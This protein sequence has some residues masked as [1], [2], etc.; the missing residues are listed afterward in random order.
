MAQ[1]LVVGN[2][3]GNGSNVNQLAL[4]LAPRAAVGSVYV[5][6]AVENL[7]NALPSIS[8]IDNV[9]NVYNLIQSGVVNF[10]VL[11]HGN[12]VFGEYVFV[13]DGAQLGTP[14]LKSNL[15]IVVNLGANVTAVNAIA[16]QISG[17]ANPSYDQAGVNSGNSSGA[18]AR[19]VPSQG[20][21]LGFVF[22]GIA[23]FI[24]ATVTSNPNAP[25]SNIV[26]VNGNPSQYDATS[27]FN[28]PTDVSASN[29]GNTGPFVLI[30][31]GVLP[32]VTGGTSS[33]GSGATVTIPPGAPTPALG[34]VVNPVNFPLT[35][36]PQN[37]FAGASITTPTGSLGTTTHTGRVTDQIGPSNSKTSIS[38][39]I[40]N[41]KLIQRKVLAGI[42]PA[43][44]NYSVPNPEPAAGFWSILPTSGPD[45]VNVVLPL[46]GAYGSRYFQTNEKGA[47]RNLAGAVQ[48]ILGS[49]ANIG[50]ASSAPSSASS[51]TSGLVNEVLFNGTIHLLLV[52]FNNGSTNQLDTPDMQIILAFMQAIA[53]IQAAYCSQWGT[54]GITIDPTIYNATMN[55]SGNTFNDGYLAGTYG[56]P[57]Q[58]GFIDNIATQLGFQ[59]GGPSA[60]C[61]VVV[62]PP[63]ITNTD[64]N[65]AN[66][67]LAYHSA[68]AVNNVPYIYL[69]I[70]A[71]GLTP[72]DVADLYHISLS[73]EI[74][75]MTVDPAAD[76]NNPEVCDSCGPNCQSVIRNFFDSNGNYLTSSSF[77]I[78]GTGPGFN[79]AYMSNS[80][81]QPPYATTAS[82][83][84][85]NL[86]YNAC[87]YSPP[88]ANNPNNP[89]TVPTLPNFP[90][91]IPS[92]PVLNALPQIQIF[93][94]PQLPNVPSA[95][96]FF[97]GL[98][99]L[100]ILSLPQPAVSSPVVLF[101][102]GSD[103]GAV[104]QQPQGATVPPVV[105]LPL[106]G[107]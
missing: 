98:A 53:P 75:E 24:N 63:G 94:F 93:A 59:N 69:P 61:L 29:D 15:T 44:A 92:I 71:T 68:S 37:A 72:S 78:A 45:T 5:S 91:G 105:K 6:V 23:N 104:V 43:N 58:P 47:V 70:T 66:G 30:V 25:L 1:A 34:T 12:G 8:V 99:T 74:A 41:A 17:T 77:F 83:T 19:L 60:H 18:T 52:N 27:I 9:G 56:T 7:N 67:Y 16:Y 49:A 4:S 81:S 21:E 11:P 28:G 80:V 65:P 88:G 35:P 96:T 48:S 14:G 57:N 36:S 64:C 39:G 40:S 86:P 32:A 51:S 107:F 89:N 20:S 90:S 102:A 62:C 33:T 38:C 46:S 95:P 85:P 87:G 84:C 103:T 55:I 13:A 100:P 2:G 10:P 82:N 76:L 101:P 97:P 54:C 3:T 42:P 31:F 22:F 50:R 106:P 26:Y 79:Y 73:H